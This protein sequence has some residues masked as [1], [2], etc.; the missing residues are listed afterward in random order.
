MTLLKNNGVLPLARNASVIVMG[1]NANDSVMQWGNYNGFPSHTVTVLEGVRDITGRDIP[2]LR[3]CDHV[4][5]NNFVSC[6]NLLS[7]DGRPGITATYWNNKSRDGQSVAVER[8]TVPVNKS[9]GGATVFAPGVNLT[10]FSARYVGTFKPEESGCYTMQLR[11]DNGFRRL[12]VDGTTLVDN[13]TKGNRNT[14]SCSFNAE[15]GKSYDIELLYGA[16]DR[17]ALLSFDIGM[18][19]DRKSVV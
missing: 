14:Y 17:T 9:T 19:K 10:D 4:I 7:S 16:G 8:L 1:P 11:T 13:S 15:K 3:G 12:S 6:F 5:N 18:I 2:Y